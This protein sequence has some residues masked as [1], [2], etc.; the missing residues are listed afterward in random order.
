MPATGC[1]RITRFR[2]G[3]SRFTLVDPVG[4]SLIVIQRD[5][6]EQLEYGGSR[7]LAG[8]ARVLDNA[9]TLRDF[10][11]DDRAATRVLEVGLHRFGATADSVDRARAYAALAELAV[12]AGD[13][14]RLARWKS[15]LDA[16]DLTPDERTTIAADASELLAAWLGAAD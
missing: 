7:G 3:Q 2:S 15:A 8:L 1:P 10:K 4:N 9:R 16:I 14:D 13:P 6:P 5:E 11:N 12:A